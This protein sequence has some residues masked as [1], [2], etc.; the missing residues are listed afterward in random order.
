METQRVVSFLAT[1]AGLSSSSV[2]GF[3]TDIASCSREVATTGCA[4]V[5]I[6]P[7]IPFHA[8][9]VEIWKYVQNYI[10]SMVKDWRIVES[11]TEAEKECHHCRLFLTVSKGSTNVWNITKCWLNINII[12]QYQPK[13]SYQ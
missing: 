9:T 8:F 4:V 13:F 5:L 6:L 3:V 12:Y 1:S 2:A 7:Q 11:L 10:E